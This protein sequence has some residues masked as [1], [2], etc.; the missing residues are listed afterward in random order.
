MC[1]EWLLLVLCRA[2]Q[3]VRGGV[4]CCGTGQTLNCP[5]ANPRYPFLS[6]PLT[7]PFYLFLSHT[8]LHLS[9]GP[10]ALFYISLF[11]EEINH[12]STRYR[13]KTRTHSS[14][15]A[16]RLSLINTHTH[17][18]TDHLLDC[19]RAEFPA[20]TQEFTPKKHSVHRVCG[21]SHYNRNSDFKLCVCVSACRPVSEP[22]GSCRRLAVRGLTKPIKEVIFKK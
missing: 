22:C 9:I 21:Q 8:L 1:W 2:C 13:Q 16:E 5:S 3:L 17:K 18:H 12:L 15:S 11:V 6:S 7:N 19:E 10:S 4:V 14:Q 20:P